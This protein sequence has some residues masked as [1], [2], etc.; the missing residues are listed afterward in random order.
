MNSDASG[1][2]A[3]TLADPTRSADP[4]S[5]NRGGRGRTVSV[6]IGIA[7]VAYLV[8]LIVAHFSEINRAVVRFQGA[9]TRWLAAAVV[10]EVVSQAGAGT[11]ITATRWK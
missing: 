9:A 7:T 5:I 8:W 4:S 6:A 10:F 3:G 2:S 1:H 11:R